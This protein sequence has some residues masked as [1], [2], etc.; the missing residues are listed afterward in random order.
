MATST[1]N[2]GFARGKN[3]PR[4]PVRRS[5]RPANPAQ[6]PVKRANGNA[7]A[8]AKPEPK[9]IFQKYF[10]SV[11]TRTYASQ[12]KELPNGNHLLVLT[13]GKRDQETGELRKSRV[14]IYGEDFTS[15]FR[16]LH[17]TAAFIRANPLP[18]EVRKRRER[19]WAKKAREA[20]NAGRRR[21][22]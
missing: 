6:A 15:F 11:G 12:V 21:D 8:D 4:A 18:E 9:I 13:E 3:S 1:R 10:K 22:Q 16:L 2:G 20:Q 7:P 5:I 17:E 19:F 14:F